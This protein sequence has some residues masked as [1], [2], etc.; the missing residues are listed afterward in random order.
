MKKVIIILSLLTIGF[1]ACKKKKVYPEESPLQGFLQQ[2]GAGQGISVN[3][4]FFGA[5]FYANGF[6]FTPLKNGIIKAFKIKLP[7]TD[8]NVEVTLWDATTSLAV[9]SEV[10]NISVANTEFV[11][12]IYPIKIIEGK[13][14]KL[15]MQVFSEYRHFKSGASSKIDFPQNVG[16]I[17]IT[18]NCS[19]ANTT[20][21]PQDLNI[22]FVNTFF[23]DI[24]FVFQQTD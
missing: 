24:D 12:N 6:G 21:M 19:D 10:M 22:L 2:S 5:D 17:S 16:N 18:S 9:H 8:A 7:T 11:K 4:N 15:S 23:G 3:N 20:F 1:G 13:K 14:Y